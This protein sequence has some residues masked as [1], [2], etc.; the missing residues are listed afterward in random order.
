MAGLRSRF[1][2]TIRF[3]SDSLGDG[4]TTRGKLA[5][6]SGRGRLA[7]WIAVAAQRVALSLARHDK[8]LPEPL[9][10]EE[11]EN[12]VAVLPDTELAYLRSRCEP[13][14]RE[15]FRLVIAG[16]P[17]RDRLILRFH[18]LDGVSLEQIGRMYSVNPSTI[19]RWLSTIRATIRE[20]IERMLAERLGLRSDESISLAALI[21]SDFDISLASLLG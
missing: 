10:V 2:R 14:I 11:L 4:A 7:N 6:Y 8:V 20:Q 18:L 16:L 5:S 1:G 13:H 15:A 19:S 9:A 21:A 3:G 12:A 17:E